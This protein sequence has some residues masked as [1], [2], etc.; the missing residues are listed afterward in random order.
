MKLYYFHTLKTLWDGQGKIK[1]YYAM[2]RVKMQLSA[3]GFV[4]HTFV[5]HVK[6]NIGLKLQ[7]LVRMRCLLNHEYLIL[8]QVFKIRTVRWQGFSLLLVITRSF[9]SI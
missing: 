2:S 3:K 5:N 8:H 4:V 1:M 7:L 6:Y 9:I